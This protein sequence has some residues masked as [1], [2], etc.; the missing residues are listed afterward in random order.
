[1]KATAMKARTVIVGSFLILALLT[2]I[3]ILSDDEIFAPKQVPSMAIDHPAPCVVTGTPG[4][5]SRAFM[6]QSG[7]IQVGRDIPCLFLWAY[8]D[9][10]GREYYPGKENTAVSLPEGYLPFPKIRW[11]V[12]EN[13]E[14]E[15]ELTPLIKGVEPPQDSQDTF[16]SLKVT[17]YNPGD[18]E[19]KIKVFFGLSKNGLN[20]DSI[21]YKSLIIEG[22]IVRADNR[23][24]MRLP[25]APDFFGDDEAAVKNLEANA[26]S[27]GINTKATFGYDFKLRGVTGDFARVAPV[28]TLFFLIPAEPDTPF[29]AHKEVEKR[30]VDTI[31]YWREES[32]LNRIV[33]NIPNRALLD[34]F[35]TAVFTLLLEWE[36]EK[37]SVSGVGKKQDSGE[38]D[39]ALIHEELS[40]DTA[41]AAMALD[42]AGFSEVSRRLLD[43]LMK[44]Q[45][46][47][48]NFPIKEIR[49]I[50]VHGLILYA[51][52]D[53]FRFTR[54]EAWVKKIYPA[55][56]RAAS[57]LISSLDEEIYSDNCWAVHALMSARLLASVAADDKGRDQFRNEA[58]TRQ[59]SIDAMI[60]L[61]AQNKKG[62]H[63]PGSD[64]GK[65][66][67]DQILGQ[68][69]FLWPEPLVDTQKSLIP[70]SFIHY[71]KRSF[72]ATEGGFKRTEDDDMFLSDGMEMALPL[73]LL[74]ER[75]K[76]VK[77]LEFIVNQKSS[78]RILTWPEFWKGDEKNNNHIESD[79]R[80]WKP[81]PRAAALF[82][83]CFRSLFL[84]EKH[85]RL[86]LGQGLIEDWF[87]NQDYL[88]VEGGL[89][90]FGPVSYKLSTKKWISQMRLYSNVDPANGLYVAPPVPAIHPWSEVDGKK[91]KTPHDYER[92]GLFRIPP[93]AKAIIIHW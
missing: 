4:N 46:K 38:K 61:L 39:G 58:K 79:P 16:Y 60:N 24:V 67:Y 69:A 77:V 66:D 18:K 19:R 93:E 64:N 37:S 7:A 36:G 57:Y 44:Q 54:D 52:A 3:F 49:A 90:Y 43:S 22:N 1:V 14:I 2:T 78:N 20:G 10:T 89:T 71:W 12:V 50:K 75:D 25:R 35:R 70:R 68:A 5:E 91:L 47:N 88:E 40:A 31:L 27:T 74:N 63:I 56:K 85:D 86:V 34:A 11:R 6:T 83:I 82:V 33:F 17:F 72:A 13:L 92:T 48:G 32:G 73:I 53:H 80:C 30:I 84:F 42:R 41:F 9:A 29:P 26:D 87:E 51:L 76:A 23:T 59:D 28:E 21:P 81:S 45:Q 62:V 65:L 55:A 8:D 15:A